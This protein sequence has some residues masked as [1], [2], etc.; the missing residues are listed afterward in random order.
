MSVLLATGSGAF[1]E[2][3]DYETGR[4]PRAVAIGD[5]S[6]DGKLDIVTSNYAS[7]TV[8]VRVGAGDGTFGSRWEYTCGNLPYSVAIGD[9]NGDGRMDVATAD[10]STASVSVLLNSCR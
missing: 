2:R 10:I 9:V 7:S 5:I 4:Q 6:G 8:T 1:A 3:R